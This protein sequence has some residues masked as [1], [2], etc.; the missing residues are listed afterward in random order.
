VRSVLATVRNG[1]LE[2][3]WVQPLLDLKDQ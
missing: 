1:D 2:D 3:V